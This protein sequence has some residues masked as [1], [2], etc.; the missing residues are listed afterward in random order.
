MIPTT[1]KILISC[2]E[3][4]VTFDKIDKEAQPRTDR[5]KK[6][7]KMISTTES[8]LV[9]FAYQTYSYRIEKIGRTSRSIQLG[10]SARVVAA[11]RTCLHNFQ[12]DGFPQ[13]SRMTFTFDEIKMEFIFA[14]LIIAMF[15]AILWSLYENDRILKILKERFPEDWRKAGYPCGYFWVDRN[16]GMNWWERDIFMIKL[17]FWWIRIG[18]IEKDDEAKERRKRIIAITP[19]IWTIWIIAMYAFFQIEN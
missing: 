13:P 12:H 3:E 15:P 11:A 1:K 17:P 6:K 18:W 10:P 14:L 9:E 16:H 7:K 4:K 19:V 8:E 2:I 5:N